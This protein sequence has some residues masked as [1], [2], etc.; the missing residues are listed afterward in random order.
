MARA[1]NPYLSHTQNEDSD[2]A[3]Q[4]IFFDGEEAIDKWTNEDSLYGSRHLANEMQNQAVVINS[5]MTQLEAMDVFILLDLIGTSDTKFCDIFSRT[6]SYYRDMQ[7]I[8]D[9][10]RSAGLIDSERT[11]MFS[12]HSLQFMEHV[13]GIED[14]H[15]PFLSKGVPVLHLI[16]YPFPS[17]WHRAEDNETALN[18]DLI[19][20]LTK[21]LQVFIVQYLQL[22]LAV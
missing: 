12:N 13:G 9:Q 19:S 3:L 4:L 10:L 22:T 6:L 16:S 1:L 20:D 17:V 7:K 18:F 15:I 8:E 11:A 14:D 21:I 5:D 2:V